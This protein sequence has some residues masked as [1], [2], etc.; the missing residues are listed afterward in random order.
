MDFIDG[1]GHDVVFA[2]GNCGQ[3]CPNPRCDWDAGPGTH[4]SSARTRIR[5]C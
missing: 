5:R 3:F 2:A 1:R 4:A